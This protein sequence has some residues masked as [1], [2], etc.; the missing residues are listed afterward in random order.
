M[1]LID[2][3]SRL[4]GVANRGKEGWSGNTGKQCCLLG[5]KSKLST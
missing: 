5:T 1:H 2:Y 4:A 3:D